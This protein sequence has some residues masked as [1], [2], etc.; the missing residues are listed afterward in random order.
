MAIFDLKKA[1]VTISD[2][3][4]SVPLSITAKI[5]DGNLTFSEKRTIQYVKDRG[6]LDTVREGDQE[7]VD[8]K[9]EVQWI[10]IKGDSA[11][12]NPISMHDAIKGVGSAS[13]WVSS[14]TDACAPYAVD[15]KIT[16]VP[17][18]TE[19]DEVILLPDFRWE[20]MDYDPKAGT[21]S[22]SGKCNVVAATTTRV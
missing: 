9:L 17:C 15:L 14:A 1:T 22:V 20:S 21:I 4:A 10:F 7:P 13:A 8:V 18:G 3:T 12:A 5:G 11:D 19:D 2:G 6:L 16:Y